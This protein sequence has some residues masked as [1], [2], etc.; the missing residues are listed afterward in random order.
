[1][2]TRL[3]DRILEKAN[4]IYKSNNLIC[5][6]CQC[7][8]LSM[9]AV[10]DNAKWD[11]LDDADKNECEQLKVAVSDYKK[12][13]NTP[14]VVA[15]EVSDRDWNRKFRI[16]LSMSKRSALDA[17]KYIKPTLQEMDESN[18]DTE[19]ES[20]QDTNE[21]AEKK[22]DNTKNSSSSSKT[23]KENKVISEKESTACDTIEE[24]DV[25]ISGLV[26]K[27]IKLREYLL[28]HIV[29]Q[30]YAVKSFADGYF[31]GEF[32]SRLD[33]QRKG[34]KAI[35]L[36]AG[37]PGVGKTFLATEAAKALGIPNKRFDMSGYADDGSAFDLTGADANYK[38]PQSGDLT[39]FVYDNPNS[40]LI[41]DEVEKAHHKVINLF[42]QVLDA[43][44]LYDNKYEKNISF[45]DTIIIFTT[46]AGKQLYKNSTTYDF[47]GVSKKVIL[48]ALEKDVNPV[49]EKPFFPQA[50]CSRLASGYVFMFNHLKASDLSV[51]AAR[52]LIEQQDN[53]KNEFGIES[54]NGE[55]LATTILFSIGGKCDA[56]SVSGATKRFFANELFELF[57]LLPT[58]SSLKRIE[59]VIDYKDLDEKVTAL[60][61]L[62]DDTSFLF[63]GNSIKE[64]FTW[65][66]TGKM[67]MADSPQKARE[68]LKD[69][70][71]AFVAVDYRFGIQG[72]INYLN[73]EDI[74]SEGKI[75]FEEIR[76]FYPEVPIYIWE[77]NNYSYSREEYISLT[78]RGAEDILRFDF[79]NS[80]MMEDQINQLLVQLWQQ[81]SLEN[82]AT[83]HQVLTYDT[84]QLIDNH[85]E[86]G[87]I[88]IYNHKL[89]K[90]IDAEEQTAIVSAEERPNIHWEDIVINRDA[91]D[92]LQY[93]QRYLQNPKEYL[94]KGAKAPRGILMYGPP[95]TGKTTL[96]KVMATESDVTFLS[97]SADQFISK[98]AG[99]GPQSV[100]HIF[101]VARKYAPAILFI[102]EIDAIGSKRGGSESHSGKQEI[103]NALL[104]EMDGF[105]VSKNKPVLVMA[106]TNL[107]GNNGNTGALD[108]ALVRRF[109]RSICIDLPD[110]DSRIKLIKLL[111]KRNPIIEITDN[112]IDNLSERAIGMSPALIE[113]AVNA[114]IREAIRTDTVV[115]DQIIDEAFE[116][117]NNGDKKHWAPEELLKT[118]RHEAGHAFVNYYFGNAP[119]YLTIVARDNHGGYMLDSGNENKGSYSKKDLLERIAVTLG[120]RA[121]ELVYYG[122]EDGLT[123]G[124]SGDLQTATSIVYKM[125]CN[126]AMYEEVADGVI[127]E[128][129]RN[130]AEIQRFA[131][132]ILKEQLNVAIEIIKNNQKIFDNLVDELI[133]KT[134]MNKKEL[135]I[136]LAAN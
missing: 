58:K 63:F 133:T 5:V 119:S 48:D 112:M 109:D 81:K 25:S 93:F 45:K 86:K 30:N 67:L 77:S 34:P 44:F 9:V 54:F 35:F 33:K 99:E 78:S 23:I 90:A 60:Y 132:K 79:S 130:D 70:E 11:S 55:E 40:L 21:S 8:F 118:A 13:N 114:A 92:E 27:T 98:W 69:N 131:S 107:G 65:N 102:D 85:G 72:D 101:A 15:N 105:K 18:N 84:A 111:R 71:V 17:F 16:W 128:N 19:D 26:E 117:Y 12:Q 100:H 3:L 39:G 50:I 96:A 31:E 106:A 49:T 38:S 37:S 51:I 113:G 43:G 135:E 36:F 52:K 129:Q 134:H 82:L 136:L 53:L 14:K 88:K 120:G 122:E 97:A 64:T 103:L 83:K 10:C 108:P 74:S 87:T 32:N 125:I 66:G 59:W 91:K 61:Q 4:E 124:P 1:M 42:L 95:G 94:N 57:R 62:P 20:G 7:V 68:L 80:E 123:T 22:T 76:Q 89:S 110:K 6:N 29:G 73:C 47:S 127:P 28:E 116:K 121:A 46:N 56:R 115:T 41:I 2:Q 75:L 126:Y 104:T 24:D